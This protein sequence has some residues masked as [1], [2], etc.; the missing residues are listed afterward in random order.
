MD[1]GC[2]RERERE[3]EREKEIYFLANYKGGGLLGGPFP[4]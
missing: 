1:R 3:R 2:E 4:A